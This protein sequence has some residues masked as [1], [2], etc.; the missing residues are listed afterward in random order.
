MRTRNGSAPIGKAVDVDDLVLLVGLLLVVA[1]LWP[2][3][4]ARALMIPGLVLIWIALPTRRALVE[5]TSM[6]DTTS[7][8]RRN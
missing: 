8:R 3:Y 7:T 4:G 2:A 5:R 6:D 1:A